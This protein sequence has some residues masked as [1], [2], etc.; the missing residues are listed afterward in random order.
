MALKGINVEDIIR[1]K[2][3][4][5]VTV[6]PD[7]TIVAAARLLTEKRIGVLIVRKAEEE[8]IGVLSER[9][10][11]RAVGE[12]GVRAPEMMVEALMTR[13]LVSCKPRANPHDVM[14]R[15]RLS[16]YARG[17]KGNVKG[18]VIGGP[19]KTSFGS[20]IMKKRWNGRPTKECWALRKKIP[21]HK[22]VSEGW[23]Y[24][25]QRLIPVAPVRSTSCR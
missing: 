8:V 16:S 18:L 1:I 20:R 11:I 24:I 6:S 13:D 2:G 15:T 14:E 4:E 25:A 17:Q 5:V 23:G 22:G 3:S 21:H 7:T 12:Y 19:S 10:I 9:D